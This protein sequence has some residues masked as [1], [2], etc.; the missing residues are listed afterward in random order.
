M[1]VAELVGRLQLEPAREA[2]QIVELTPDRER[3][4]LMRSAE[5]ERQMLVEASVEIFVHG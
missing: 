2:W 1:S 3:E 4:V 5:L